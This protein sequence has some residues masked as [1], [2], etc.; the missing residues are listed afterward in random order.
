MLH[1]ARVVVGLYEVEERD[2]SKPDETQKPKIKINLEQKSDDGQRLVCKIPSSHKMRDDAAK[3]ER[4]RKKARGDVHN[5]KRL[6]YT[7]FVP[8]NVLVDNWT[9]PTISFYCRFPS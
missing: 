2:L 4:G 9:R 7:S 6:Y 3:G 8:S 5:K 1:S